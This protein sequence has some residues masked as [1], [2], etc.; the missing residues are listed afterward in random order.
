MTVEGLQHTPG[1][2]IVV[3]IDGSPG[4]REALRWAH[5]EAEL[6]GGSVTVVMAW[7]PVPMAVGAGLPPRIPDL[8]P[9][10]AAR[11]VLEAAVAEVY[12]PGGATEV[13]QRVEHGSP[14]KVLIDLSDEAD[15]LVVGGRGRGGFAG[16][17]LG[18]VSQQVAQHSHCPVVVLPA[19]TH[20]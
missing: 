16:L 6:R 12:G 11:Q 13:E 4:S 15:L 14:A 7:A 1:K 3:G 8:T 5:Q 9:D 17:A 2:R 10:V 19:G 18:S 20:G